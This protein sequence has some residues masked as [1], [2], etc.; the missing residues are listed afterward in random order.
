MPLQENSEHTQ[1][2]RGEKKLSLGEYYCLHFN[3]IMNWILLLESDIKSKSEYVES[4]G[5]TN[6]F[7]LKRKSQ[8]IRHKFDINS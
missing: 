3:L 4:N 6:R 5:M 8:I 1:W 2:S 7:L